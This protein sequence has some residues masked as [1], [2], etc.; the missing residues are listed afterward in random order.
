[1][2]DATEAYWVY[3]GVYDKN[4]TT[5]GGWGITPTVVTDGEYTDV[6]ELK[7]TD[8][9]NNGFAGITW[10]HSGTGVGELETYVTG[11]Q[12]RVSFDYK[13]QGDAYQFR[14]ENRDTVN[15][16]DGEEFTVAATNEWQHFDGYLNMDEVEGTGRRTYAI[17]VFRNSTSGD[18]AIL[19]KDWQ[20]RILDEE[21]EVTMFT[22]S[23]VG[24][25]VI[26][27]NDVTST[28][29]VFVSAFDTVNKELN[30]FASGS[31]PNTVTVSSGN[32][33]T[34]TETY[35]YY[36]MAPTDATT[37]I[38]TYVWDVLDPLIDAFVL[39]RAE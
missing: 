35:P 38:R 1:M 2:F 28:T 33:T 14:F 39:P 13:A 6:L 30:G 20:I 9:V 27:Y 26:N 10:L 17:R 4:G 37:E 21:N 19:I 8:G 16:R 36:Y 22:D 15:G 7:P 32:T 31:I 34:K 29:K 5:T 23:G 24:I 3:S 12:V 18:G 25:K 11:K